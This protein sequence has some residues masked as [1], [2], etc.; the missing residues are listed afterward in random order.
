MAPSLKRKRKSNDGRLSVSKRHQR[1]SSSGTAPSSKEYKIKD[2]I[3]E[4]QFRYK[5][6]WADDSETGET[7]SPTWEPKAFA[8]ELAI[9]AWE[10][11]KQKDRDLNR[12]EKLPSPAWSIASSDSS[13]RRQASILSQRDPNAAR[14]PPDSKG[15]LAAN[16]N[17]SSLDAFALHPPRPHQG[18]IAQPTRST[19]FEATDISLS[20]PDRGTRSSTADNPVVKTTVDTAEDHDLNPV[21]DLTTNSFNSFLPLPP[22]LPAESAGLQLQA[23]YPIFCDNYTN[24][25]ERRTDG[26]IMADLADVTETGVDGSTSLRHVQLIVDNDQSMRSPS[27]ATRDAQ[28]TLSADR[29]PLYGSSR[30][31]VAQMPPTSSGPLSIREPSLGS[32]EY[33]VPLPMSA[34]VRDL[35]QQVLFENDRE[36]K[37]FTRGEPRSLADLHQDMGEMIQVLDNVITHQDLGNEGLLTQPHA[38]DQDE[39]IW[40]E[41][42]SAKF[43]FLKQL[44]RLLRPL[45]SVVAIAAAS[46]QLLDI[47]DTF[48]RGNGITHQRLDHDSDHTDSE[49]PYAPVLLV[50]TGSCPT[51]RS[52]P[53]PVDVVIAFD[54]TFN[55]QEQ[56]MLKLRAGSD[57]DGLSP[58]L[59]LVVLC[60]SEHLALCLPDATNPISRMQTLI[61]CIDHTR[62]RVGYLPK[63]HPNVTLSAAQAAIFAAQQ[64]NHDGNRSWL[65]PPL[66]SPFPPPL[67]SEVQTSGS[68]TQSADVLDQHVYETDNPSLTQKRPRNVDSDDDA[69]IPK[70]SRVGTVLTESDPLPKD[71]LP[72]SSIVGDA[73]TKQL[74]DVEVKLK[75]S[76]DLCYEWEQALRALQ[77]RFEDQTDALRDMRNA[78]DELQQ[79]ASEGA[80]AAKRRAE[81]QAVEVQKLKAERVQLQAELQEA[82]Q[83]ML[84]VGATD[85]TQSPAAQENARQASAESERLAKKL[86]SQNQEVSFLREQYQIASNAAVESAAEVEELRKSNQALAV[87]A[88][89]EAT[90]LRAASHAIAMQRHLRKIEDLTLLLRSR[91]DLRGSAT[92]KLEGS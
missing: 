63:D 68:T 79:T 36:I 3:D 14:Y 92:G 87:R 46:G 49:G 83:V 51:W 20:S 45:D 55:A 44:L 27:V 32:R 30:D 78:L 7:Y 90:E 48:L 80:A 58:V 74:V 85:V 10:T 88:N 2:I 16:P 6:D 4:D 12:Q 89:S 25:I 61:T 42:C 70:R 15:L 34:R 65:L 52:T 77:A 31:F 40:A 5:I 1:P 24:T 37:V 84:G 64:G 82:R 38:T 33:V 21:K 62:D 18:P 19:S 29:Q 75:R 76:E 39:A 28:G 47:L 8:N 17:G 26:H 72:P 9:A 69:A 60:S 43:V 54:S 81:K 22:P 13:S 73:T 91:E 53:K 57:S 35:Y 23:K 86:A 67:E 50:P 59:R 71:P 41:K 56:H 11:R 66:T